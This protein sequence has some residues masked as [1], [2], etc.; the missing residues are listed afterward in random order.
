MDANEKI[1]LLLEEI[2]F[3][4]SNHVFDREEYTR[5]IYANAKTAKTGGQVSVRSA[6]Q[7]APKRK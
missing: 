6:G 4:T 7:E 2:A 1:I 5:R 3:N